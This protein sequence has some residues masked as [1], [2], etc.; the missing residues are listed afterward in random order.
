MCPRACSLVHVYRQIASERSVHSNYKSLWLCEIHAYAE[1]L[2]LWLSPST[3]FGSED[4]SS[5]DRILRRL[6]SIA[7]SVISL[8]PD[9][10]YRGHQPSR[11]VLL[12]HWTRQYLPLG[13]I[14]SSRPDICDSCVRLS[15]V[16][17]EKIGLT[18]P[19]SGRSLQLTFHAGLHN[20][21]LFECYN[22]RAGWS[23]GS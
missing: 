22:F 9:P 10:L 21:S 16:W 12:L 4:M 15:T 17:P 20:S 18:R 23:K 11:F 7:D 1:W 8:T 2:Q 13:L 3:L 14:P 19:P 5:E 6:Y